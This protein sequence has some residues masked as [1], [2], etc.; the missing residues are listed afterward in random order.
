MVDGDEIRK[1]REKA[2]M[3]RGTFAFLL[4]TSAVTIWRWETGKAS[5]SETASRLLEILNDSP[6]TV[7]QLLTKAAARNFVPPILGK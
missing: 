1:L 4:N 6:K 7:F 2:K 5:P 3:S